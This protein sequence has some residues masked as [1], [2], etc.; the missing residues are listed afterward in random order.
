[1]DF[2]RKFF[3]KGEAVT[4][5]SFLNIVCFRFIARKRASSWVGVLLGRRR[6]NHINLMQE[7]QAGIEWDIFYHGLYGVGDASCSWRGGGLGGQSLCRYHPFPYRTLIIA[8]Y[9][10][11]K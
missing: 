7:T 6:A 1:M 2:S 3:P 4:S 5:F 9:F 8:E 10:P 11:R